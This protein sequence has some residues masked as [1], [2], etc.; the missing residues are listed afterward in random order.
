[1]SLRSVVRGL[2]ALGPVTSFRVYCDRRK[3]GRFYQV[4]VLRRRDQV[5]R[6]A[7]IVT[8]Q[9]RGW[10][11]AIGLCHSMDVQ[12]KTSRGW[13][14]KRLAGFVI[15]VRGVVG[16]GYVSHEMTHAA[17]F[18]L[19]RAGRRRFAAL[20]F[21]D[22]RIAEPLADLQGWLVAQFWTEFYRRF[23]GA[24]IQLRIA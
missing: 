4:V 14:P 21:E 19:L 5:P 23:P 11:R 20:P 17:H 13:R 9:R 12:Q 18:R 2:S 15:L 6:A 10:S 8:G 24:P 22:D 3:R 1:L 7:Q 16:S